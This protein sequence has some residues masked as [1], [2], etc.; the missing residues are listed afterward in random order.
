MTL[1]ELI[2]GK[3][4]MV[5]PG[6]GAQFVGMGEELAA[7]SPAA[8]RVFEEAD[9]VLGFPLTD[10]IFNGPAAQ[11]ED[12]IN[13]QPAI[14]AT[15][16]AALEALW[17][18]LAERGAAM[19]PVMVAGHSL[20]EFSALVA[21]GALEFPAAVRLVR[22]RGRLMKEAGEE[23]PGG[24]AAILGMEDE[25]L[26]AVC[27]EASEGGIVVLAN[28][29][30]PGQTVISGEVAALERAMA[31]AKERGAKRATQLGVSIASHSPLMAAAAERFAALVAETPLRE[32]RVPVVGNVT[33]TPLTTVAEI[34][35]EL[36]R[37]VASPV[38]WMGSVRTMI[39]AGVTTFLDLGPGQVVNGLIKRI[40]RDV[41]TVGTGDLDVGLPT[42]MGR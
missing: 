39:E 3:V 18:R 8:K 9:A 36:S 13:A 37:Q 14:L 16:I 27:A 40:S 5:F 22:E 33:A 23:A 2:A 12:T 32:P 15:S 25:A 7:I 17:E 42:V 1:D 34:A 20:G 26:A 31:L 35:D 19:T 10:L 24:M 28:A 30:C 6:Q 29:N 38:N 21:A 4:A 11:L 41:A